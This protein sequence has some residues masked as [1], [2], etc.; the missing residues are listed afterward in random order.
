MICPVGYGEKGS[1]PYKL[2]MPDSTLSL[3]LVRFFR[4]YG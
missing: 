3:I 4:D 2:D 1:K